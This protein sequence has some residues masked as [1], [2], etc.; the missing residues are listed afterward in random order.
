[1]KFLVDECLSPELAKRAIQAGHR[2]SSHI[3]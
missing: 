1:M 2:E 3:T